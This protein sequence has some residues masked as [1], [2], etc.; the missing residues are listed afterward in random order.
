MVA[1]FVPLP[2]K[3]VI[4]YQ[5][6]SNAPMD[7]VDLYHHLFS[8]LIQD[9]RREWQQGDFPFLFVQISAYASTPQD[10]WGLLRDAQRRTLS[11]VNTGMAVTIDAGNEHNVH[12]AN[13]QIVGERLS[14]LARKMVFGE[15]LTASGPL[16]QL[17]YPQDGTMHVWFTHAK[18]LTAKGALEGFEVAGADGNFVPAQAHIEG[19]R[20]IAGS[21]SVPEPRYVR[22]A[23]R[24]FP[25]AN[26]YNGAGL[27]ASTFT[28][29]PVP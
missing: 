13:K 28:S 15:D 25:Q 9:W 23:W 22:Y 2:I 8:S 27:P 5:G 20:V 19:D 18:G 4:W 7:A 26:L 10:N 17:A 3:G 16:F 1:P 12:P 21:A 11:L 29:S 24:N 6:E 14:L